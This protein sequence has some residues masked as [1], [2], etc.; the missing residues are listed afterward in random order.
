MVLNGKYKVSKDRLRA[1]FAV[2]SRKREEKGPCPGVNEMAAFMDGGLTT[3]ERDAVM[4]HLDACPECYNEWL[5]ASTA[6]TEVDQARNRFGMDPPALPEQAGQKRTRRFGSRGRLIACGAALAASLILVF[7]FPF[8]RQEDLKGVIKAQYALVLQQNIM[9]DQA[10][11]FTDLEGR[12]NRTVLKGYGFV[13]TVKGP[14]PAGSAFLSGIRDGW[15][16]IQARSELSEKGPGDGAWDDYYRLG[17]WYALITSVCGSGEKMPNHFWETQKEIIGTFEEAI[18]SRLEE[19]SE[20]GVLTRS[21]GRIKAF[22]S[23]PKKDDTRT[24]RSVRQ[25]LEVIIESVAS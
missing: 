22:L 5:A 15:E 17:L 13:N 7:W 23:V 21:L 16:R 10:I 3:R 8:N 18:S 11:F 12:S 20:A 24:C 19:E 9:P 6:L 25:E 2:S 14:S 1:L 4:A